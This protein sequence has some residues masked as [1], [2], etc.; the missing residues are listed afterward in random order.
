MY[1]MVF[2]QF[3]NRFET[4]WNVSLSGWAAEPPNPTLFSNCFQTVSY[5]V[6]KLFQNGGLPFLHGQKWIGN[7]VETGF[8]TV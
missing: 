5:T 4:V 3:P 2:K 6:S 7:S 8:Y 1:E